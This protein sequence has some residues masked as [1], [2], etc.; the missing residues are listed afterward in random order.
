MIL[1]IEGEVHCII[2]VNGSYDSELVGGM[3]RNPVVGEKPIIDCLGFKRVTLP[4]QI[5]EITP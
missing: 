1:R 2:C 5:E 3:L 4:Q